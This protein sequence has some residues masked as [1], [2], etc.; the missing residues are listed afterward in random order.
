[1]EAGVPD[2]AV[3]RVPDARLDPV[4]RAV[5]L[6]AQV[7]PAL[8]H[9]RS[10]V[11]CRRAAA[12]CAIARHVVRVGAPLPDVADRVEE[13]E[14]VREKR[15]DRRAAAEAV[16]AG[17]ARWERSLPDVAAVDAVGDELVPPRVRSP[18]L[19]R[20]GGVLPLGLG[21]K[22]ASRPAAI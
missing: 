1:P 4:A 15:I 16:L 6:V 7:R 5:R 2:R 18:R 19:A 9:L 20:G 17:V 13:T 10:A 21:G 12:R 11:A 14:R 3:G 22:P 8:L